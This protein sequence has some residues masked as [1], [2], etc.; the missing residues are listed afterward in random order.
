MKDLSVTQ[1]YLLC[2]L[3]KKGKF[4]GVGAEKTA[5]LVAAGL[6]ELRMEGCV[7]IEGKKAEVTGALPQGLE[8]VRP[9]Y[10]FLAEKNVRKVNDILGA[11]YFSVTDRRLRALVD[12]LGA[13]LAEL[14]AVEMGKGGLLGRRRY[15]PKAEAVRAVVEMLRAE[16][17]EEGAVS[18]DAAVLTILLGRGKCLKPYFSKFEQKELKEKLRALLDSPEG[19][20]VKGMV[21]YLES[22]LTLLCASAG[23]SA[24]ATG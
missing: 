4:T 24:G 16:L 19:R 22:I 20:L 6:L 17:L 5:C 23:V 15:V 13:S 7:A 12:A 9:L 8:H 21:D 10:E 14:G 2:A 3:G 1:A 11:Y 18:E